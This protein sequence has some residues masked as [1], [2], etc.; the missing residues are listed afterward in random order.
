[1]EKIKNK[2][3]ELFQIMGF[4]DIEIDIK[5]DN[6]LKDRELLLVNINMDSKQADTFLKEG[7]IGLDAFQHLAR[8]LISKETINQ[9]LLLIDINKYRK[10][11]EDDLTELAIKTAQE[12]RKTKKPITLEPMSAYERR[13]VHLKLAE[14]PDIVTESIGEE[15][16]RKVV[17]R[18]YP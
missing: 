3:K 14:Q 17:V 7:A 1:M 11:R 8:V 9:A 2:I 16:E 13:F 6:S 18:L 10:K 5:K 12:V 4:D 15:P